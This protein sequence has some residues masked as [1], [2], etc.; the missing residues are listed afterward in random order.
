MQEAHMGLF[1][2]AVP[3]GK[4]GKPLMIALGALLVSKWLGSK[5][6]AGADPQQTGTPGAQP[7]A[8]DGGLLGGLDG[9][10]EKLKTAG[11]GEKADSWVGTGEN[12]PIQP[13]ELGKAIGSQTLKDIAAKA[14]VSEEELLKQLSAALPGLVDKLT[15]NGSIPR[16]EQVEA[17]LNAA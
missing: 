14:G 8:Q 5:S 10:L 7:G 1:D 9:L 13:D 3:G 15:P 4:I 12:K 6:Q 17:A 11:H 16:K 2:D